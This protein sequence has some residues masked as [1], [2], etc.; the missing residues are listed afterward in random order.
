ME[1]RKRKTELSLW[2]MNTYH[3]MNTSI[4]HPEHHEEG[5]VALP[6]IWAPAVISLGQRKF[7]GATRKRC[8]YF[9]LSLYLPAHIL[10]L[11]LLP[12]HLFD[13]LWHLQYHQTFASEH[14]T[15]GLHQHYLAW[16]LRQ[17][18]DMQVPISCRPAL[19]QEESQLL[20]DCDR[21]GRELSP[22]TAP[23]LQ[24]QDEMPPWTQLTPFPQQG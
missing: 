19:R 14:L 23:G 18:A 8:S 22:L 2:H 11:Y 20:W 3:Q 7:P 15:P 21:H 6:L 5:Q 9:V 24:T 1:K 17:G 13:H 4:G 12:A 10:D 16:Q